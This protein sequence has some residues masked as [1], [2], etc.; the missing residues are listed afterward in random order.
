[1][2]GGLASASFVGVT[3][4]FML[5][6]AFRSFSAIESADIGRGSTARSSSPSDLDLHGSGGAEDPL[7]APFLSAGAIG[8]VGNV[9]WPQWAASASAAPALSFDGIFCNLSAFFSPSC[10]GESPSSTSDSFTSC[11]C[12]GDPGPEGGGVVLS[13]CAH[14]DSGMKRPLNT[15]LREARSGAASGLTKVAKAAPPMLTRLP[16][17]DIAERAPAAAPVIAAAAA[18]AAAAALLL[19]GPGLAPGAGVAG[20][21][22]GDGKGLGES[23]RSSVDNEHCVG[24][25]V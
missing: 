19:E 21:T 14:R 25:F 18:A 1:M 11:F 17:A 5:E 2:K 12:S 3:T 8:G 24:T 10:T 7:V 6:T 15:E 20:A 22:G 13:A 4:S 23:S 9:A 16:A